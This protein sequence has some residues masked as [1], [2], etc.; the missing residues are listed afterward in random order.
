MNFKTAFLALSLAAVPAAHAQQPDADAIIERAR[1]AATL[2]KL[3]GDEGLGG[4]LAKSGRR[5]PVNLHLKGKSIQFNYQE[6]G[7]WHTFDMRLGDDGAR[8]MEMAGGQWRKFPPAKLAQPIAGTDLTFEDLS[9][10]FLYWP[11]AKF[12]GI[13]NVGT[14]PCYKIRLDK[15]RG[16]GGRYAIVHV[17]VSTKYGAF[18]QVHGRDANGGLLKEFKVEDVMQV[19]DGTWTLKKMQV[20]SIDPRTGRRTG[21]TDVRFDAPRRVGRRGGLR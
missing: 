15:P 8:L 19:A 6:N 3:P 12:E 13:E 21:I 10:P 9:M 11:N 1:V 7:A 14:F 2:A 5:V 18:I 20:A 4:H 16:Q 17:W